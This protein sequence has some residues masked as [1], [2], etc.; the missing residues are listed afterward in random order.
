MKVGVVGLGKIGVCMAGV[1]ARHGC[2]VVGVDVNEKTL[3]A[4]ENKVVPENATEEKGLAELLLEAPFKVSNDY[5][6]LKGSEII[7]VILPTPSNPDG[8]YYNGYINDALERI[9]DLF[10]GEADKPTVV[11]KST[12][13]PGS[14]EKEFVPLVEDIGIDVCYSAEMVGLGDVI[15]GLEY[16]EELLLGER[17]KKSGDKIE[18]FYKF[19]F[20]ERVLPP[21]RRMSLWNAELSKLAL[22]VFLV[23]KVTLANTIA[24]LC[25]ENKTGNIE[26]V[27]SFIGNDSRIGPKF[28]VTGLGMGGV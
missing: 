2:E 1:Y 15:R 24:R 13:T 10:S 28:L 7:I 12:V 27:L 14:C 4:I 18:G 26:D 11:I 6:I 3:A 16:P 25:D 17:D 20:R 22:N 23:S 19:L 9:R 8:S 21:L 5:N